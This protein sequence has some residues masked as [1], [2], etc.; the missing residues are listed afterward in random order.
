MSTKFQPYDMGNSETALHEHAGQEPVSVE[1]VD[2]SRYDHEDIGPMFH[3]RFADGFG[4]DVFADELK[5]A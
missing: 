4:A 1:P 2:E 5:E 3:V